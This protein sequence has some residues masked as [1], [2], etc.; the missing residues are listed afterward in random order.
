[1]PKQSRQERVKAEREKKAK[2]EAAKRE[3]ETKEIQAARDAD[4]AKAK[5]ALEEQHRRNLKKAR[6]E[7]DKEEENKLQ[8]EKEKQKLTESLS[9]LGFFQIKQKIQMQRQLSVINKTPLDIT[10]L[11]YKGFRMNNQPCFYADKLIVLGK[12]ENYSVKFSM[13]T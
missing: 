13:K 1:M 10:Y 12:R 2:E 11:E 6:Q 8:L 7:W 3:K 4:Y 5:A 9:T